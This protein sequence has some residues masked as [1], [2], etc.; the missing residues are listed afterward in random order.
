MGFDYIKILFFGFLIF[1][2]AVIIYYFL[3]LILSPF[4]LPQLGNLPAKAV[5]S[6]FTFYFSVVFSVTLA[7]AIYKNSAKLQLPK[8]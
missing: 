7:D 8:S 5:G 1:I 3:N 6:L 2:V 4:N